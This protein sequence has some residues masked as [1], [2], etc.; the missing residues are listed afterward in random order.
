MPQGIYHQSKKTTK[1]LN[2]GHSGAG[3]TGAMA[4]LLKAGYRLIILDFDNGLP[5]LINILGDDKEALERLWY[6]TFT[7]SM[8]MTGDRILPKGNPTAFIRAMKGLNKWEFSL[9]DGSDEKYNLGA[10]SSWGPETILV[11][12]SLGFAGRA[13]LRLIKQLAGH[14]LENFTSQPDYGQAMERVEGMLELLYSDGIQ[15]N[16]IVN[17]HITYKEDIISGAIM[18]FPMALGSKLPE[19]VPGY[20]NSVVRS[21]TKGVGK[22]EKKIIRTISEPG[23]ELK[24]PVGP[25]VIPDE[26][27]IEDGLLTIFKKLQETPWLDPEDKL[28]SVSVSGLALQP[29]TKDMKP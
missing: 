14:K 20:F 12:D 6:E 23:L 9:G 5:I 13:A 19:K 8:Q 7:D 25:G 29:H 17:S 26:L 1:L 16:V 4:C 10:A 22:S 28:T 21:M 2:I 11:I 15:C 24:L 27:P 18:G 3:K